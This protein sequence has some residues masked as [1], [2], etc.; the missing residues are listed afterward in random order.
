MGDLLSSRENG[1]NLRFRLTV[2]T[3][4]AVVQP[5]DIVDEQSYSG[6]S[7]GVKFSRSGVC[8]AS[9]EF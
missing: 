6:P 3:D 4:L 7:L 2:L 8:D 5:L 1:M 9:C